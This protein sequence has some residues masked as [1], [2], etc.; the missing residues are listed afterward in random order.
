MAEGLGDLFV[1]PKDGDCLFDVCSSDHTIN[2]IIEWLGLNRREP[3]E[4][5]IEMA[6]KKL[7][8][9]TESGVL[10]DLHIK[11][12]L[13]Y[14]DYMREK[15]KFKTTAA[16]TDEPLNDRQID[17][18]M[19]QFA[20][21]FEDFYP[22]EFCMYNISAEPEASLN[23]VSPVEL[24]KKGYKRWGCV[25]NTD[26]YGGGGIHWV[27]LYGDMSSGREWTIEYFN[28]SSRAAYGDIAKWI[29]KVKAEMLEYLKSRGEVNT[30][31]N[32]IKCDIDYQKGEGNECGV[33]CLTYIWNRL[34][35]VGYLKYLS[36]KKI[37]NA[38]ILAMR[39]YFFLEP[40]ANIEGAKERIKNGA[41]RRV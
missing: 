32:V 8:K 4:K 36:N 30:I 13:S 31:I 10:K 37:S 28:S 35:D 23:Q 22:Y 11:G 5:V 27:C 19:K 34:N 41:R 25:V 39:K 2:K 14:D 1:L 33:Y 26:T 21:G 3:N 17:L 38:H 6:K 40:G 24:Y 16:L 12:V 29:D 9:G 15:H 20:A 7:G 18:T